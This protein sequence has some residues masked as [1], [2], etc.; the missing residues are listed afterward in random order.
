MRKKIYWLCLCGFLSICVVMIAVKCVKRT[1]ENIKVYGHITDYT[2]YDRK[3]SV[4]DF[5][6]FDHNSTYEDIVDRIGLENGTIGSGVP[7][8]YY[9][10]E[11]GRFV[12]CLVLGNGL[13]ISVVNHENHEY[14]L[15]PPVLKQ[16][17]GIIKKREIE[18][19]RQSEMNSILWML[20]MKDW[21]KPEVNGQG[22]VPLGEYSVE[23]LENY[24]DRG[25]TAETSYYFGRYRESGMLPLIQIIQLYEEQKA[26]Y[27]GYVLW[28]TSIDNNMDYV[29]DCGDYVDRCEKYELKGQKEVLDI[30]GEDSDLTSISLL[31]DKIANSLTDFLVKQK[32]IKNKRNSCVEFWGEDGSGKY[33]CLISANPWK[34]GWE[35]DADSRGTKY[36]FVTMDTLDDTVR[37]VNVVQLNRRL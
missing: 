5:E 22:D 2:Y 21:K 1:S 10:L 14:Y 7:R 37:S 35:I 3:L 18:T 28:D 36:Y 32:V 20:G 26:I 24:A 6:Q 15:L 31:P 23:M 11:D 19:A 9:E 12:I 13:Y 29:E 8:A 33:V 25:I 4:T 34:I 16:K 17:S 27:F 30:N